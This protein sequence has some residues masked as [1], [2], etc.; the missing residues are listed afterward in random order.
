MLLRSSSLPSLEIGVCSARSGRAAVKAGKR[1]RQGNNTWMARLCG[2]TEERCVPASTTTDVI[3]L[4]RFRLIGVQF[5]SLEKWVYIPL[6]EAGNFR[7]FQETVNAFIEL[8]PAFC[9]SFTL[10]VTSLREGTHSQGF[11]ICRNLSYTVLHIMFG[12]S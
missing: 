5:L 11:T 4:S 8:T 2:H 7:K 12:I 10:I 9:L 3:V 1:F 6:T